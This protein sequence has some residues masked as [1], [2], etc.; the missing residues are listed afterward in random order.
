MYAL[1]FYR[2]KVKLKQVGIETVSNDV[3]NKNV[4]EIFGGIYIGKNQSGL[5]IGTEENLTRFFCPTEEIQNE[6]LK[7]KYA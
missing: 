5:N 3:L 2:V 7:C 4:N 1:L 6:L